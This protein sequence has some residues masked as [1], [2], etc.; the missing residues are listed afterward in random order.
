[1]WPVCLRSLLVPKNPAQKAAAEPQ[2][3]KTN[4]NKK[5]GDFT[6]SGSFFIMD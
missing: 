2:L 6:A 5:T 3:A 4:P 1:M